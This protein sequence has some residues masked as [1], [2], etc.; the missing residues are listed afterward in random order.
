MS[1][2]IGNDPPLFRDS[3][4][5]KNQQKMSKNLYFFKTNR[6]YKILKIFDF[7]TKNE[8]PTDARLPV[9]R[10]DW[11]FEEKI[12]CFAKNNTVLLF[13]NGFSEESG[14]F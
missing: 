10:N 5:A 8:N 9:I 13:K 14:H 6:K 3:E 12:R 7:L 1:W 4:S 2:L 11:F